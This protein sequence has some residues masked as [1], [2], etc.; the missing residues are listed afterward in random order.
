MAH[1]AC[2]PHDEATGLLA[3]LYE[4]YSGE[5]GEVDHILGVHSLNPPSM[6]GHVRCYAHLMRGPSP[7]SRAQREMIA[8]AVSAANACHY[9]VTHHGAGLRRLTGDAELA[10]TVA[11][12][13]ARADATPADRAMLDYTVK[14]TRRPASMGEDDVE[15]L[16]GHGFSDRAILG[17]AQV[18]SYFSFVNRLANGLGVELEDAWSEDDLTLTPAELEAVASG[19]GDG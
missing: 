17:I 15:A 4:R 10:R 2:V 1:I 13:P 11:L 6:E 7:L 3:R 9:C 12:D 5:E 8:V 16:R 14:L 18:A 19:A